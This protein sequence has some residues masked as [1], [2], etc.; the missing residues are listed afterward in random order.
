MIGLMRCGRGRARGFGF[1]SPCYTCHFWFVGWVNLALGLSVC[2]DGPHVEIHLPF[3]F[4]RVGRKTAKS[5][6]WNL[7][8][9]EFPHP[10]IGWAP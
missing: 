6:Y 3:G 8:D 10:V 2:L 9:P 7:H 4:V 5:R 1:S